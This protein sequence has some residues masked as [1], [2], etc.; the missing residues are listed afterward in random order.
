MSS[1]FNPRGI[2]RPHDGHGRGVGNPGGN[3][4]GTNLGPCFFNGPGFGQGSGRGKSQG[5]RY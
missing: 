4:F 1:I 2:R 3:R 5:R